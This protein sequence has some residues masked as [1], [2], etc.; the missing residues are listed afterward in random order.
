MR[1]EAK[2]TDLDIVE[3]EIGGGF[4]RLV[5]QPGLEHQFETDTGGDRCKTMIRLNYIAL[6]IYHGFLLGDY[7]AVRDVF[8]I[9]LAMHFLVMTPIAISVNAALGRRPPARLRE[10]LISLGTLTLAVTIF[11]VV[12]ASR[13]PDRDV[14]NSCQALVVLFATVM[15]RIRF[16]HL[17]VLCLII[18]TLYG[19]GLAGMDTLSSDRTLVLNCVFLGIV[20]FSLVGAYYLEHELRMGYL[21]RLRDGFRNRQLEAISLR[22][23]L[24]GIANRRALDVALGQ[25][26]ARG[27]RMSRGGLAVALIDI[28]HFKQFNDT[29]GHQEGDTCL[30]RVA[31]IIEASLR[32]GDQVAYR[33]GGEE[34]LVLLQDISLDDARIAAER[35]RLNVEQAR[36]LRD[37]TT[38]AIVT[39]SVLSLIHI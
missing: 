5:F 34:F 38:Q 26:P 31:G 27:N 29:N 7:W 14:V 20:L 10:G 13:M 23:P 17:V 32:G 37:P 24:T 4:R 18:Q 15:Q 6:A 11:I 19:A 28:D 35:I 36:I 33:F 25:P 12:S 39:V 16:R 1:D 3:R 9:D 22:D 2:G 21:L 8:Q 30:K